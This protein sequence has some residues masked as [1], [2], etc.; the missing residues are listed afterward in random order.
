MDRRASPRRLQCVWILCGK[1]DGLASVVGV[2]TQLFSLN[3]C[4]S[5]KLC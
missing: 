2:V 5:G 3:I 4:S 1:R